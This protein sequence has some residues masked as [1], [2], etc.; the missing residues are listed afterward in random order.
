MT[1]NLLLYQNCF[2][3]RCIFRVDEMTG[4]LVRDEVSPLDSMTDEE[5]EQEAIKLNDLIHRLNRCVFMG[6]AG[7]THSLKQSEF[8]T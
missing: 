7:H 4:G 3:V 5:K 8:S 2:I 6:S 1:Q